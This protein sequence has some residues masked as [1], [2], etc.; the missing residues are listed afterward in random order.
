VQRH[1]ML[2]GV[3]CVGDGL[4]LP[5][6]CPNDVL[7]Q[8]RFYNGW[9]KGHYISNLLIFGIDGKIIH[10]VLNAPGSVHDSTLA[11]WGGFYESMQNIYLE[12]GGKC[13]MDSAFASQDNPSI[14]KSSDSIH[15]GDGERDVLINREAIS[16]RQ[17]AE[18]GMHAIQ[19]AFPRIKNKFRYEENGF[20]AL[21]LE[22]M[23]LLYNF[24]L[25]HVGLNQ[26]KTVYNKYLD[27]EADTMFI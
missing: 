20:R 9:A 18:W 12:C 19:S 3:F 15:T 6:Q 22:L 26:I 13:C 24:R 21:N 5:I 16:L 14:I 27:T 25:H 8:N 23:V 2:D 1:P 10:C 17:A 11:E 4:K 7:I